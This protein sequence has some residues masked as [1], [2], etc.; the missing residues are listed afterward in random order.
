MGRSKQGRKWRKNIRLEREKGRRLD[1]S[2]Q[3]RSR[4]H[5]ELRLESTRKSP[6]QKEWRPEQLR[7]LAP[8]SPETP[9]SSIGKG[10]LCD[11]KRGALHDF[12][13][14]QLSALVPQEYLSTFPHQKTFKKDQKVTSS[15]NSRET[16]GTKCRSEAAANWSVA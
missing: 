7:S 5:A 10:L 11:V 1:T 3:E 9:V 2:A 13:G 6:G 12:I 8:V 14:F 15:I 4:L 16:N